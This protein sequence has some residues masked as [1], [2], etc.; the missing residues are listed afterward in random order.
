MKSRKY[1]SLIMICIFAICLCACSGGAENRDRENVFD[2]DDSS[3]EALQDMEDGSDKMPNDTGLSS[4]EAQIKDEKDIYTYD[5]DEVV[6]E[7]QYRA[8]GADAVGLIV[9]CDG[10]AV[11]FHT[12]ENIEDEIVQVVEL[13]DGEWKDIDISFIPYGAS[14]DL[15]SIEIV[16]VVDA[17]YDVNTEDKDAITDDFISG[18]KYSVNYLSGIT[19]TMNEAGIVNDAEVYEESTKVTMTEELAEKY[20]ID[21]NDET[22]GF[23]TSGL[24]NGTQS[25]WYMV[26]EGEQLDIDILYYG[27]DIDCIYTSF[28]M[29]NELL[30]VFDGKNY[31]KC[32]VEKDEYTLISATIDTSGF[33]PGRYVIYSACGNTLYNT[34]RP[35]IAF[36]LEVEE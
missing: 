34:A 10:I 17:D 36:V 16:D 15:V 11:P 25:L 2:D 21:L 5:G 12:D 18:Q 24:V 14:G 31:A 9:L 20:L 30:P 23:S 13:D 26:K 28:Y 6:I 35:T 4:L 8:E 19:V 32:S 7:Y 27:D 3:D 29:D 33:E 1:I 22:V